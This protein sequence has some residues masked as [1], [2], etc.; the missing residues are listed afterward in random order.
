MVSGDPILLPPD[1]FGIATNIFSSACCC[2]TDG[3]GSMEVNAIN[4][5]G[6]RT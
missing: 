5:A 3:D 2:R 6:A 4:E 1:E